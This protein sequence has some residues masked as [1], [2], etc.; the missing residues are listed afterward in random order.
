LAKPARSSYSALLAVIP[1]AV[2]LAFCL[3]GLAAR[4][5]WNNE[6]ATWH[7]TS[8]P[9]GDFAELL[10][11]TDLVHVVYYLIIRGWLAVG[12]DSPFHLRLPSAVAMALC[13]VLVTLIGRRL[14]G[15]PVGV[16]AGLFFAVIPAVSRYGQET[17]SYA[18]VT[19]AG[20]FATLMLLRALEKPSR[21][22]LIC[23]GIGVALMGLIHFVSLTLLAAHFV[24]WLSQTRANEERTRG[25]EE[26]R[27]RVA[28]AGGFGLLAVI[29][30]PALS[31]HQSASISWIK[32]DRA[33][34]TAFPADMF[35]SGPVA[36][37]LAVLAVV[38]FVYL[39][40]VPEV[41]NR[42]V[43]TMLAAWALVPPIFVLV[44]FPV[45]HMFLPRYVLVVLPAWALLAA[46]GAY[47]G[48]ALIWRF[49]GPVTATIAAAAVLWVALPSHALVRQSPVYGQPDYSGAIMRM[50]ELQE[51]GDGIVFNDAFGQLSDLARQAVDYELRDATKPRDV[52]LDKTAAQLASFSASECADPAR[53]IGAEKRLWLIHT[54]SSADPFDGIPAARAQL[55]KSTYTVAEEVEFTDVDLV[56]L[57]RRPV[58]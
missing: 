36:L 49:L 13:A 40:V 19:V 34:I 26:R 18:L 21:A 45:L 8:I 10:R 29:W 30:L 9:I 51:P 17:R 3:R 42:P 4:S 35:L 48:G 47:L 54:G 12:G 16:F 46:A 56:L 24:L 43:A 55:L 33:A 22:R 31:S 50:Q 38:G 25:N 15:T 23:Y 6:Y 32:A 44:T 41:R 5:M 1:G 20:A 2:A 27:W 7:A 37:A 39:M 58:R 52:F 11:R 28:F 14:L 57:Q 53:C